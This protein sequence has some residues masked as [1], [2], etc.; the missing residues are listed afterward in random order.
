MANN[1]NYK[2][3]IPA[4]KKGKFLSLAKNKKKPKFL[5]SKTGLRA[6]SSRKGHS[7]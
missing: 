6:F 1:M 3:L 4:K 2:K 7:A 5:W